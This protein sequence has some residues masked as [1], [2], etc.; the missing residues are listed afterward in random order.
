[1]AVKV[2]ASGAKH[3]SF[4]LEEPGIAAQAPHTKQ[5][6]G[7]HLMLT[8]LRVIIKITIRLIIRRG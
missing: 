8:L 3:K 6:G 1:M 5:N 7:K 2:P 4:K